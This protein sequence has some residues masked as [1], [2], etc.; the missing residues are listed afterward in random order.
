MNSKTKR[1]ERE[2]IDCFKRITDLQNF[3]KTH[4]KGQSNDYC[5]HLKIRVLKTESSVFLPLRQMFVYLLRKFPQKVLD[6]R[7]IQ[8]TLLLLKSVVEE[9]FN[10]QVNVI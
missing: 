5:F 2:T 1:S 3:L 9:C 8:G 6:V 10:N 7:C 4:D